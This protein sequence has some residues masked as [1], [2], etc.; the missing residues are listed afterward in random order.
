MT[1]PPS[2]LDAQC[3]IDESELEDMLDTMIDARCGLS[4]IHRLLDGAQS[5]ADVRIRFSEWQAGHAGPQPK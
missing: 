2:P 1:K 4:A 3:D 5:M